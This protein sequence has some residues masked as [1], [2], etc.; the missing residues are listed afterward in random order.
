MTSQG[1]EKASPRTPA[2]PWHPDLAAQQSLCER[3]IALRPDEPRLRLNLAA[4]YLKASRPAL[5]WR[6]FKTFID[7]WP[8]HPEA[9]KARQMVAHLEPGFHERLVDIGLAGPD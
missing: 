9:E 3:L 6:T 5:A 4:T 2:P 7:R 1:Q 8:N